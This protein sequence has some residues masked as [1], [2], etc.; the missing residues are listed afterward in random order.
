MYLGWAARWLYGSWWD[1]IAAWGLLAVGKRGTYSTGVIGRCSHPLPGTVQ[2]SPA[3]VSL[4]ATTED[5]AA[6]PASFSLCAASQ[7]L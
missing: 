2:D 3:C 1:C 7:M 4:M 6:E 5:I